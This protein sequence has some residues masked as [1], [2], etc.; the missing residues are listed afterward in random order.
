M[1]PEGP[2]PTRNRYATA[3]KRAVPSVRAT[4][5][6]TAL[7]LSLGLTLWAPPAAH[8]QAVE[9]F[10]PEGGYILPP[11]QV[12]ELFERDTNHA[13]LDQPGPH[14]NHFLM[15]L[16]T[17][18][19]T[20]ERM[21]EPTH[22]LA[23]L[24]VRSGVD[25]P[26]HL[27]TYGIYGFRIFSLA[28][29]SFRDVELPP[30][31]FA[32]DFMWSPE[33]DR[34]AFLAHLRHRTQVW[35]AEASTGSTG[36]VSDVHIISSL[37]TRSAGQGSR[38]SDM[39]QWTPEGTLITLAEPQGRGGQPSA[40]M[41]PSSPMIRRT[42][43]EPFSSRTLPF[44]MEDAHDED[45]FQYF[46][47]SQIVELGEEAEPRYIGEPAMY[48]SISLSPDGRHIMARYVERPFSFITNW[49]GFPRQTVILDR[50][51]G[52]EL[53]A[54]S[55]TPLQDGSD[56]RAADSIGRGFE[57]RPDGAGLA[58]IRSGEGPREQLMLLAAPFDTAQARVV[59]TS[60]ARIRSVRYDLSGRHA[61]AVVPREGQA[62]LVHFDLTVEDPEPHVVTRLRTEGD[63]TQL[64]GT[65]VASATPNGLAYALIST[66]GGTVYLEGLGYKEDFRHQPFVDAVTL[67]TG[68]ME[69]IFEGSRDHYERPLAP[70][71]PDFNRMTV[72]RESKTEFPD[73]YLW[74]R[75]GSPGSMVKLTDNLDPFPELTGAQRIDY[76]FVRRDG[77]EV[78]ARV[79]LPTDYVPGTRVPAIFWTY[80]REYTTPEGY[81]WDA[82]RR[83]N[84]NAFH[85]VTWLRW[86]DIWLSQGYA[87]VHPDVPIVGEN[88]NDTYMAN[89]ADAMYA[90][91]R[92]TDEL[93]YVDVDRIGHGGHSYG[94]FATVNF[95][96]HTPF[97][98]AGIAG[99]GAYN[100][101]LTP[102]GFQAE[103]RTL[104]EAPHVYAAISPFFHAHQVE[105][106]LLIYHG[107]DDNNTGTWPMQS[108]RLMHALTNLGKDAA[109]F[110]YPFESHTPRALE[111]KLD[112]WARFLEWFDHYVKDAGPSPLTVVDPRP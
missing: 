17:E 54:L 19:S 26:W 101:T 75:G 111:T 53:T 110:M 4:L 46:T 76:S 79:S 43:D 106:P 107:A 47:I 104:W 82:I 24:E 105:T 36:P 45:L 52:E 96:A 2:H 89:M 1:R 65:L 68:E 10:Q 40:P 39:L 18:L 93:G 23:G 28:H 6:A 73:S 94:G 33:G 58:Y 21:A 9:R 86:S 69:R 87:V 48:A 92:A 37:A 64:S 95:A 29:R 7:S 83:R 12:Q 57:W 49:T 100:R 70:L 102:A 11:A 109:L 63:P 20:L 108:V 67:A 25:R 85:H 90:A 32:S 97:F 13:T 103:R 34:I 50:E 41:V 62:D 99:S 38:A 80:P 74:E 112:M 31:A 42:P 59:A 56:D 71:D 15:P 51:T 16:R 88:Y 5:R 60:D 81:E 44:L 61:L 91:I 77:V 27:D 14:G 3:V 22:R 30:E 35:I 8:A 55:F 66:D 72:S 84:L 98:K 78:Q